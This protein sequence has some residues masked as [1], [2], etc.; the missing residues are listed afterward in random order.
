MLKCLAKTSLLFCLIFVCMTVLMYSLNYFG[1]DKIQPWANT[2]IKPLKTAVKME[3]MTENTQKADDF[4]LQNTLKTIKKTATIILQFDDKTLSYIAQSRLEDVLK[5]QQVNHD[6][7]IIVYAGHTGSDG[8]YLHPHIT[9]LQAQT[10]ARVASAYT[11]KIKIKLY[12]QPAEANMVLLEI[13]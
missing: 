13:L 4:L 6:S 8:K 1:F 2:E 12:E 10:V 9:R 7:Q 5:E 3:D 11:R